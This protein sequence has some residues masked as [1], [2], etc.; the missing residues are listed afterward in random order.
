VYLNG[1]AEDALLPQS[2]AMARAFAEAGVPTTLSVVADVDHEFLLLDP[3]IPPVAREWARIH[4]WL[5]ERTGAVERGS[6]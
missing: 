2:L 1:G 3:A 5:A 6:L 4:E